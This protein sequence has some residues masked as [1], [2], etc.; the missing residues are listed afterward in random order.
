[1]SINERRE[2]RLRENRKACAAVMKGGK[3]KESQIRGRQRMENEVVVYVRKKHYTAGYD[4]VSYV[5]LL[6]VN[7]LTISWHTD[8]L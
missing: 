7:H 6:S 1:M 2:G 8:R 5:G 3:D 4:V